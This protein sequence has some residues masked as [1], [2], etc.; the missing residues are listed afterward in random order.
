[1]IPCEGENLSSECFREGLYQGFSTIFHAGPKEVQKYMLEGQMNS[2]FWAFPIYFYVS[3][4]RSK[5]QTTLVGGVGLLAAYWEPL[6]YIFEFLNKYIHIIYINS[7][8]FLYT[9]GRLYKSRNLYN[10]SVLE[11]LP[12]NNIWNAKN[13]GNAWRRQCIRFPIALWGS[14]IEMNTEYNGKFCVHSTSR[15]C[16]YVYQY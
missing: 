16:F 13:N 3:Q 4:R 14:C 1:M 15:L 6:V 7:I 5:G 12:K 10:F 8:L 9:Y 11:K 2:T